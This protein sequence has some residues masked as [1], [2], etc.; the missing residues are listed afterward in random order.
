MIRVFS[1]AVLLGLSYVA[2]AETVPVK[3]VEGLQHGFMSLKTLDGENV[4]SG[5]MTQVA[6][7]NRLR[8]RLVFRFKDGSLY[9]DRTIFLQGR[10]FQ[11]IEDRVL[12]RGRSFK[13]ATET[14]IMVPQRTV[15]VRYL[16]GKR[17]GET[18]QSELDIPPDVS[19]GMLFTLLKNIPPT[20]PQTTL[21]MVVASPKAS[22]VKLIVTPEGQVPFSV[23]RDPAQ[24][25]HFRIKIDIPGVKGAIAPLVGKKPPDMNSGSCRVVRRHSSGRMHHCSKAAPFG[26]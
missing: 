14:S 9:E 1:Y 15:R 25:K 10:T 2:K 22:L 4:A 3:Y 12:H 21:S 19:N 13:E 23:G 6:T 16:E 24:V 8:S 7:G 26:G 11:L 20:A 17:K 5:E 18:V